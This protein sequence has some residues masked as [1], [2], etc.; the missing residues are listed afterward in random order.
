VRGAFLAAIQNDDPAALE[1]VDGRIAA[2][3][4]VRDPEKLRLVTF[5]LRSG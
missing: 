5:R 3:Y 2:M 1:I 4:V